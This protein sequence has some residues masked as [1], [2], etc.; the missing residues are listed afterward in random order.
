MTSQ[1]S[2]WGGRL[3]R[4]RRKWKGASHESIIKV[5][6]SWSWKKMLPPLKILKQ[7][8]T[9]MLDKIMIKL[10]RK[11][12]IEKAKKL[13]WQSRLFTVPKKNSEEERL[14]LDLSILNTFIKCPHF[15]ML[16]MREV[17]LLL[18]RGF[19][20]VSLDLRDG[21]W[22]VPVAP[23]AR[24]FLGFRYR[25]QDWQF[26]AM[27][28]GLNIAPRIF[29]KVV[30]HVVKLMAKAGIWCLP[31]LDDLLIVAQTKEDCLKKCKQAIMI[32][33]SL[34]WIINTQ[35]SRMTP[36]QTFKWL[37]VYFNLEDHTAMA[38]QEKLDFLE[39]KLKTLIT[40]VFN[41]ERSHETTRNDKLDGH[42]RPCPQTNDVYNEVH[43]MLLQEVRPGH[44][45]TTEQLHETQ[46]LQMG[47]PPSYTTES[48][49]ANSKHYR[50]DRCIVKRL[51]VPSELRQIQRNI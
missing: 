21:F 49:G 20:T 47:V 4:F 24:P 50:N 29:T 42:A 9:P 3:F 38:P 13:L 12:I 19:W 15:K 44:T 23:K 36:A 43:P 2:L 46:P 10:R 1:K 22:H 18:P 5:G 30:A 40:S 8:T 28:F 7:R 45:H 26:R 33:E 41:Q 37:G 39:H 34:G 51:G 16:N 25:N 32:L 48:G 27:P 11:R 31:Y 6:L 17:K 14:I 35:K